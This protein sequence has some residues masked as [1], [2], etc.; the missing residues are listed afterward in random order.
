MEVQRMLCHRSL[1][2]KSIGEEK[3]CV[4]A[5]RKIRCGDAGHTGNNQAV[6]P[7]TKVVPDTTPIPTGSC[8]VELNDLLKDEVVPCGRDQ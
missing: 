1:I 3:S 4:V 7:P 6:P 2:G 5:L 8:L